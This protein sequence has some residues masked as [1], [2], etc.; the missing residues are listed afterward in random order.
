MGAQLFKEGQNSA[1]NISFKI[2]TYI[3]MFIT[4]KDFAPDD[5]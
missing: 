3:S 4:R 2:E 1:E 5:I